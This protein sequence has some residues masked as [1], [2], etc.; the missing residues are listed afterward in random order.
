MGSYS[1]IVILWIQ[2]A[3]LKSH[4]S[5]WYFSLYANEHLYY[6]CKDLQDF[7][8]SSYLGMNSDK[9]ITSCW[10]SI[11]PHNKHNT[12]WDVHAWY[13][14]SMGLSLSAHITTNVTLM[15][16]RT[17]VQKYTQ[18][19]TQFGTSGNE[20][21]EDIYISCQYEIDTECTTSGSMKFPMKPDVH[22]DI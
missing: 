20:R 4:S 17:H 6:N 5:G 16:T 22:H 3:L 21:V 9:N 2:D 18:I 7:H 13:G 19:Y 10:S 14:N 1:E 11:F 15:H 8:F 12:W